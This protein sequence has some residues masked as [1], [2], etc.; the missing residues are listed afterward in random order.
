VTTALGPVFSLAA[1]FR[2]ERADVTA[3]LDPERRD[4]DRVFAAAFAGTLAALPPGARRGALAGTT[5]H[6]AESVVEVVFERCGWTPVWH[7]IGAGRHG[8]DLLLLGPGEERLFAVE[9][10]GTL[11]TSWWPRLRRAELTQMEVGWL[12]KADNPGMAEWGIA[13]GDVYGAIVLVNF[14]ELRFKVAL[15]CDFSEWQPVRRIDELVQ[16]DWL[17][18]AG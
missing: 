4:G 17:D 6:V 1:G 12:D 3:C 18:G 2:L 10:K 16:L 15:S 13:S 7:F 8:V 5:G 14:A 9:V 11:R